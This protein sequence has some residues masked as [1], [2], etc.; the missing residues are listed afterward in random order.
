MIGLSLNAVADQTAYHVGTY[1][2]LYQTQTQYQNLLDELKEIL[3]TDGFI[4]A[5]CDMGTYPLRPNNTYSYCTMANWYNDTDP[6]YLISDIS[7]F[8]F[9]D[10]EVCE[11]Y[12]G[13]RQTNTT[14]KDYLKKGLYIADYIRAFEMLGGSSAYAGM[15]TITNDE[16]YT[17]LKTCDN[18]QSWKTGTNPSGQKYE[19]RYGQECNN[20][21]AGTCATV[22]FNRQFRCPLG[23]YNS[24]GKSASVAGINNLECEPCPTLT[25][26][27]GTT[28]ALSAPTAGNG[29]AI[30]QCILA[31]G[32]TSYD[33][34]GD[35]KY[36]NTCQYTN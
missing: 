35:F 23:Y 2:K 17:C 18:W 26:R 36:T 15:V 4:D 11:T 22:S 9:S 3:E 29:T 21:K 33:S 16:F 27:D 5:A 10:Q 28:C 20:N 31:S 19:Y 6:E 32:C 24:T 30:T 14:S 13:N 1:K 34:T 7:V 8:C 25:K 12:S